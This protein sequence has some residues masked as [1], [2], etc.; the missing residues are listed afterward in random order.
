[1]LRRMV[2]IGDS[3]VEGEGDVLGMEGWVG[4]LRMQLRPA[5]HPNYVPDY[6]EWGEI[7]RQVY[8]LGVGGDTIR[9]V[10]LRLGEALARRP[11]V[12]IIGCGT[13]DVVRYKEADGVHPHLPLYHRQH[14]WPIVLANAK[15]MCAH[16]LVTPGVYL[17]RDFVD[18]NGHGP[19]HG[20]F[21]EHV[22]F[23]QSACEVAGVEFLAVPEGF[24]RDDW[25]S[26]DLH[27]NAEGYDQ[28]TTLVYDKLRELNW[29]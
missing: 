6:H 20:E 7:E 25:R 13:N 14:F 17:E 2:C 12:M 22:A 26:H 1:M 19:L 4:R 5:D 23:I 11:D 9:D 27:W 21:V 16:V 18:V 15:A 24:A 8:N 3:L 10:D 28:M 29:I